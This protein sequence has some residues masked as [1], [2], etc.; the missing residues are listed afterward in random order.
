MPKAGLSGQLALTRSC[1]SVE[2]GRPLSQ[3][4]GSVVTVKARLQAPPASHSASSSYIAPPH[5]RPGQA[6][7]T[8]PPTTVSTVRES[9]WTSSELRL[10]RPSGAPCWPPAFARMTSSAT[11]AWPLSRRIVNTVLPSSRGLSMSACASCTKNLTKSR[12]PESA[13]TCKGPA[14]SCRCVKCTSALAPT[15]NSTP[16]KCPHC[17]AMIRGELPSDAPSS[18]SALARHKDCTMSRCLS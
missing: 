12:C 3:A 14:R 11:S 7:C 13:A 10:A 18:R 17:D 4:A 1:S 6:A 8:A 5:A 16:P 9:D 2:E 15:R